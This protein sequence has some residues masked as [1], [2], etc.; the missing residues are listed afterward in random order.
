ME[1]IGNVLRDIRNTEVVTICSVVQRSKLIPLIERVRLTRR[2]EIGHVTRLEIYSRKRVDARISPVSY[3][4][5]FP[6]PSSF[7][8][9]LSFRIHN[10]LFT[11]RMASPLTAGFCERATSTEDVSECFD[12][13]VQV[14]NV[15][16]I[17]STDTTAVDRYRCVN[18]CNLL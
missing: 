2:P 15:K 13:V 4:H 6:S 5:P 9:A 18:S 10:H 12:S 17:A 1:G 8:I 16:K 14:L 11:H 7:V 3:R